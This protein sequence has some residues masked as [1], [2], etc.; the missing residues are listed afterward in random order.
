M[1]VRVKYKEPII[2]IEEI[3]VQDIETHNVLAAAKYGDRYVLSCRDGDGYNTGP[4]IQIT[5]ADFLEFARLM[6]EFAE[7][8]G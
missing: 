3:M 8:E 4:I 6:N 1:S 5:K 7:Q 2:P